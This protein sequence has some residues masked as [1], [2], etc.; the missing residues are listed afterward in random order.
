MKTEWIQ[1][2]ER[3]LEGNDFGKNWDG[4]YQDAV[5]TLRKYFHQEGFRTHIA[6]EWESESRETELVAIKET[7]VVRIPGPR[8]ITDDRS[9]TSLHSKSDGNSI[10][11]RNKHRAIPIIRIKHF[12]GF[13]HAFC[14]A[15]FHA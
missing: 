9:S 11:Q 3:F 14:V 6:S 1:R 10:T 2:L 12:V 15:V 7:L 8:T 5:P 4:A 13:A